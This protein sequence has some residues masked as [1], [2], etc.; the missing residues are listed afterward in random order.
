MT[1]IKAHVLWSASW[2]TVALS[3]LAFLIYG[4]FEY[5]SGGSFSIVDVLVSCIV[6]YTLITWVAH[7]IPMVW[8]CLSGTLVCRKTVSERLP[9]RFTM[10][11]CEV[12]PKDFRLVIF[13]RNVSPTMV[14]GQ[15]TV[16]ESTGSD[17]FAQVNLAE[18]M[19]LLVG[20]WG[21]RNGWWS[22][23]VGTGKEPIKINLSLPA[24]R[25]HKLALECNLEWNF[26]GT[27]LENKIPKDGMLYVEA[28]LRS[29]GPSEKGH[30]LPFTHPPSGSNRRDR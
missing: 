26:I 23:G 15:I 22:R 6:I 17:V 7:I 8:F 27:R 19:P 30:A 18:P 25:L 11:L 20:V 3:I 14:R 9:C 10:D 5:L 12:H 2:L 21:R 24:N 29:G 1:N 4:R 13:F 28:T 16:K